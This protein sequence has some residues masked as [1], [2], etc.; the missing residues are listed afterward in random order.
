MLRLINGNLFDSDAEALVNPVNTFGIMGKGIARQFKK[1]YPENFQLYAEACRYGEVKIGEMFVTKEG[2]R[3]IINFP[4]KEH[5]RNPSYI[6]WI[7]DGLYDLKAFLIE[8]KVKS[9]AIP[10]LGVG[11]GGLKWSAVRELIIA[12][13]CDMD[14]DITVY[15]PQNPV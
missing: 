6:E 7:E 11:N 1:R 2:G 12:I 14:A 13:L 5:W 4:T 8:E 9:V 10:A 15:K 3:L